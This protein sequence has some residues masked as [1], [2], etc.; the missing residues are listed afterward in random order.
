MTTPGDPNAVATSGLAVRQSVHVELPP[1]GAFR[2]T[3]AVPRRQAWVECSDQTPA[4]RLE[5]ENA[6]SGV[7]KDERCSSEPPRP[8]TCRHMRAVG[9]PWSESHPR[10]CRWSYALCNRVVPSPWH[11]GA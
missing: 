2:R 5:A 8:A 6:E 3:F 11:A 9:R 10:T 4:G 1:S 7:V